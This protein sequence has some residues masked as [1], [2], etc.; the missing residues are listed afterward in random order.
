MA[1]GSVASA[2]RASSADLWLLCKTHRD[3]PS[4]NS[5]LRTCGSYL[6]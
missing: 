6:S 5:A 2:T 4:K 3:D 1:T